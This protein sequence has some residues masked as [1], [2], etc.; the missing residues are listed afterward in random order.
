MRFWFLIILFVSL[1]SFSKSLTVLHTN[2]LHS[3]FLGGTDYQ[4]GGEFKK[5]GHYSKLSHLIKETKSKLKDQP[6]LLVDGGDFYSGSLFH[7]LG[8]R[9][10]ITFN[11][12]IDFFLYN[13]YDATT[14]GNHEFDANEV[15]LSNMLS[16]LKKRK[17]TFRIVSTN[18]VISKK[19]KLYSFKEEV[20][21][22]SLVKTLKNDTKVGILGLLGPDG[23]RVSRSG[24]SE[25]TFKGYNETK[26]KTNWD[27]LIFEL[28]REIKK[29][30]KVGVDFIVLLMHGGAPEDIKI[31]TNVDGIDLIVAG[32]THEVYVRP[33][34]VKDTYI[35]QAGSYAQFLGKVVLV[36]EKGKLTLGNEDFIQ[37]VLPTTPSDPIFD[38][39]VEKYLEKINELI[40]GSGKVATD[41]IFTASESY[42]HSGEGSLLYGTKVVTAIRSNLNKSRKDKIDLYFSSKALVREGMLKNKSYNLLELFQI[43]PIGMDANFNPGSPVVS[44]YLSKDEVM[45]LISFLELYSKFSPLFTPIYA[46]NISFEVR[47]WGIPFINRVHSLKMNG[48]PFEK[49][50]ELIHVGTNSYVGSYLDKVGSMSYGLIEFI[51]KDRTGNPILEIPMSKFSEFHFFSRELEERGAL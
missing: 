18:A 42:S 8:P 45:R 25:L 34:R 24:R 20:I 44:F 49:W 2:D 33:I 13:N 36:K 35:V 43:L 6:S 12:E 30:K 32:H 9:E 26:D 10:K 22:K 4:E 40:S 31:A 48:I 15:G 28:H 38:K 17:S 3:R 16:K 41:K 5:L 39:R 51:A 50:P 46:D 14:L 27:E 1:P 37:R 21:V 7:I 29:L 47:N 23:S 19:S 11:P